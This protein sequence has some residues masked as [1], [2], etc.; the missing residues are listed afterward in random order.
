MGEHPSIFLHEI[1]FTLLTNEVHDHNPMNPTGGLCYGFRGVGLEE[2]ENVD[3]L[4]WA[5]KPIDLLYVISMR[6]ISTVAQRSKDC[7]HPCDEDCLPDL[8]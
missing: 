3:L 8:S 5:E 6:R 4:A 1:N 2:I 7:P